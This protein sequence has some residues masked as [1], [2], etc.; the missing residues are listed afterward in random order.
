MLNK[1]D[2][3]VHK[4]ADFLED[5]VI[6]KVLSVK[7]IEKYSEDWYLYSGAI[8]DFSKDCTIIQ[9]EIVY[10]SDNKWKRGLTLYI[11]ED[12]AMGISD[13]LNFK[14]TWDDYLKFKSE[15]DDIF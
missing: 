6:C 3:I 10:S 9:S 14:P 11:S 5:F 2:L 12:E 8:F 1:G 13:Y 15:Y 4:W 7:P